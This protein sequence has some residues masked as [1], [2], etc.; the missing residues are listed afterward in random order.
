MHANDIVRGNWC[1]Y[2]SK[3]WYFYR[4]TGKQGRIWHFAALSPAVWGDTSTG[5]LWCHPDYQLFCLHQLIFAQ[6]V[7]QTS[8]FTSWTSFTSSY[9]SQV[10][11]PSF[12]SALSLSIALSLFHSKLKTYLFGRS[13]PPWSLTTDTPDWLSRLMGPFFF[14]N[15]LIGFSS[16]FGAVD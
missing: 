9:L 1:L 16:W 5:R 7:E 13:F 10:L 15:L 3:D 6:P 14:S 2:F 4:T 8:C 12:S 11:N